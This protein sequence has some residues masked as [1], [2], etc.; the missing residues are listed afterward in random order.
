MCGMAQVYGGFPKARQWSAR[1]QH[2][3]WGNPGKTVWPK[4]ER[5]SW[6][7]TGGEGSIASILK[8]SIQLTGKQE[9]ILKAVKSA[10][11]Q[12]SRRGRRPACA[13]LAPARTGAAGGCRRPSLAFDSFA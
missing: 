9:A 11:C 5:P 6:V 8:G 13:V 7:V 3:E 2:A 12:Q 10:D 4:G 1:A